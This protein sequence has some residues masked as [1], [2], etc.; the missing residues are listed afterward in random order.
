MKLKSQ[1]A[2]TII[3]LT[4]VALILSILASIAASVYVGY[5]RRARFAAARVTIRQIDLNCHAYQVDLGEFPLSSSGTAFGASLPNPIVGPGGGVQGCGYMML[6]LLHSYNGNAAAPASPRWAGPYMEVDQEQLGD[7]SGE[8]ITEST[9]P[10]SVCLLDPWGQ[11]Y[12]YV[13]SDDYAAFGGTRQ[14]NTPFP[15]LGEMYYNPS[16][17]QVWSLGPDGVTRNSPE[18]GLGR[19]D[20]NNFNT[21]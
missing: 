10:P 11:P 12:Q 18:A 3:E 5:L 20:V 13:R 17:V 8:P 21:Q 9:P 19:D 7:P 4:V 2:F 1:R 15:A 14:S 6:C 16:T